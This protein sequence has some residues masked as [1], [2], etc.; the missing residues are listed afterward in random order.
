MKYQ[1]NEIVYHEDIYDYKEPLVVKGIKETELLL[2]GDYSGG[3]HSVCQSDW[4]SIQGVSKIKNYGYK[5]KCR[6]YVVA[7]EELAK[8]ITDRT[9]DT[10]V[11]TMFDLLNM[12]FILT[13]EI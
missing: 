7:V 6:D 5:K 2:E 11:S 12:V 1:L 8:P 4:L 3:T 10:M 9:S 13:N